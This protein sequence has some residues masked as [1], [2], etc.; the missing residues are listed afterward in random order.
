MDISLILWDRRLVIYLDWQ[1]NFILWKQTHLA[2][3]EFNTFDWATSAVKPIT[4]KLK[5]RMILSVQN[6]HDE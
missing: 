4:S 1:W 2:L 5:A 3:I 6:R